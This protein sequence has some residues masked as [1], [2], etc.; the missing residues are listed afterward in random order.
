MMKQLGWGIAIGA[1]MLWSAGAAAQGMRILSVDQHGERVALAG[2]PSAWAGGKGESR[3]FRL[4][5]D[6]WAEVERIPT[7]A[8]QK[9]EFIGA[10]LL[11]DGRRQAQVDG[12]R[13]PVGDPITQSAMFSAQG[14]SGPIVRG[15]Q[16][17]I[18]IETFPREPLRLLRSAPDGW[19]TVAE[20]APPDQL[21]WMM[22]SVYADFDAQRVAIL[23]MPM[24]E[25]C[26]LLIYESGSEGWQR[27]GPFFPEVCS[28]GTQLGGGSISLEGERLLIGAYP[29]P[30]PD[31][32]A[33]QLALLEH[34]D[35]GW[36]ETA[37][38]QR[39]S[40][41]GD[42]TDGG[43][44]P[45]GFGHRVRL[46]EG[47]IHAAS[48]YQVI[49]SHQPGVSTEASVIRNGVFVFV[50]Q[51]GGWQVERHHVHA[52]PSATF[53]DDFDVRGNRMFI[54]SPDEEAAYVFV[55]TPDGY[56]L[57]ARLPSEP[58]L[59]SQTD[60]QPES[61]ELEQADP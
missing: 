24:G 4:G 54:D 27:A 43:M 50:E 28:E 42:Y 61:A 9:L 33:G 11:I 37:R 59:P 32:K 29:N 51:D 7:P 52:H 40:I 55:R 5:E 14:D 2:V 10:D 36:L 26:G 18:G 6:G 20:L 53:G 46:A 1:A 49:H 48:G 56:Q 22:G 15:E 17:L 58:D 3:L 45:Y 30:E 41:D 23:L 34:R 13:T 38:I 39:P 57:E 47:M 8:W 25:R 44:Q 16:L 35:G 60:E 19:A 31:G 12:K 21:Q